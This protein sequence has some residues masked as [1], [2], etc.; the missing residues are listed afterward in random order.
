MHH[1]LLRR[2]AV[3]HM[4]DVAQVDGR[5]V[6]LLHRQVVQLLD[7]G[8]RVV[9]LHHILQRPE[10]H[11]AGRGD[12]VLGGDGVG[13]V[14]RRQALGLQRLGIQV[15]L[16][17]P[18][19]A[20]IGVG[21]RRSRHRRQHRAHEVLRGVQHLLLGQRRR[22]GRQL[23]DRHGRGVVVQDQRRGD[24][25]RQLLQHRLRI[26]GHLG[27]RRADVDARLEV[28]LHDAHAG[29]RG[30]FQVV[31]AVDDGGEV[32]FVGRDDAARHLV[33]RQAGVGPGDPDHRHAD[34]GED[35]RR[36]AQGDQRSDQQDQQRHHHEGVGPRQ[37][38]LDDAVHS[39]TPPAGN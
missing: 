11:E 5:A 25:R 28:D 9:E 17:L 21:N 23:Q 26:G 27:G 7:G 16:D 24:A 14:L 20:A 35:V 3:A 12:L 18:D 37:R 31:D 36:G 8:D 38:D 22:R 4:A 29:Q 10:L 6:H 30:A 1:A 34:V 33:R 2:G 32:A 13:H 19:L 39:Q 15:H